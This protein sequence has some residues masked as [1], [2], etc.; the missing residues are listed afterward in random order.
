MPAEPNYGN[1]GAGLAEIDNSLSRTRFVYTIGNLYDDYE[2]D[3]P[4]L[5]AFWEGLE[6]VRAAVEADPGFVRRRTEELWGVASP[7]LGTSRRPPIRGMLPI[8][9][10]TW[11]GTCSNSTPS[12]SAKGRR[13]KLVGYCRCT[14]SF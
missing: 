12:R 2:T 6:G 1:A 14:P 8:T 11:S 9:C 5:A 4:I 13:K 3:H 10:R 7:P